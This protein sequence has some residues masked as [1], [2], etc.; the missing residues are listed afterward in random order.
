MWWT[1]GVT[2]SQEDK[3]SQYLQLGLVQDTCMFT[4]GSCTYYEFSEVSNM[5]NGKHFSILENKMEV[6]RRIC[7]G[8]EAKNSAYGFWRGVNH[9]S[10]NGQWTVGNKWLVL[11][12]EERISNRDLG[13]IQVNS[14]LKTWKWMSSLMEKL[15]HKYERMNAIAKHRNYSLLI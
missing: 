15:D 6:R 1:L 8:V 10:R 13:I 11:R 9:Q 2:Q 14:Y 3:G 7:F 4:P 5:A 12:R